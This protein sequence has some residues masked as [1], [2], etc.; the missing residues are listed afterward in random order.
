M[1]YTSIGVI[2]K[3]EFGHHDGASDERRQVPHPLRYQVLVLLS[4]EHGNLSKVCLRI[5]W[6]RYVCF[7]TQLQLI[8]GED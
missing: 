4:N 1:V 5:S 6:L 8:V 2:A 3:A 7:S